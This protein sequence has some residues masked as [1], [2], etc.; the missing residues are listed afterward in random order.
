MVPVIVQVV[1]V[2][3]DIIKVC[4]DKDI[5]VGSENIIDE[6]LETSWGIG[7]AKGHYQRLKQPIP[8][9]ECCLPLLSFGHSDK[10]V[11]TS[12][13]QLHVVLRL[14]QLQESLV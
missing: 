6:V 4:S 10:I 11:S 3:E 14:L 9:P 7:Q 8:C 2:D 1:A 5:Q 12:D 13:V